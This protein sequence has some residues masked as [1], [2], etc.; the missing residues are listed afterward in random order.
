[1]V[2]PGAKSTAFVRSLVTLLGCADSY[3]VWLC[4]RCR[5]SFS[6]F[7]FA[8]SLSTVKRGGNISNSR[9]ETAPHL[10]FSKSTFLS[11]GQY[12]WEP[13]DHGPAN[14]PRATS[15]TDHFDY[16][17]HHNY[18]IDGNIAQFVILSRAKHLNLPTKRKTSTRSK[19]FGSK[20]ALE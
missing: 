5:A 8:S 14:L 4:H 15:Q 9:L 17:N 12:F 7:A 3:C 10:F 18:F 6:S 16:I 19:S 1:M 11:P 2:R 13:K 20:P